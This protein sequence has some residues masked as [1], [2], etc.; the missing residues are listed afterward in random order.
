MSQSSLIL[1]FLSTFFIIA[2]FLVLP[3]LSY[4]EDLDGD[5]FDHTV[6]CDDQNVDVFPDALEVCD[7][8]DNDCD[9][10]IDEA[11]RITYWPDTDA[12]GFGDPA[13]P[14]PS[15]FE[16]EGYINNN[17]DCN[18]NDASINPYAEEICDDGIDNNC[19][20]MIDEDCY[21]PEPEPAQEPEAQ[22]TQEP[23]AEPEAQ[24]AQEPTQEPEAQPTQ[25]PSSENENSG[26]GSS[27]PVDLEKEGCAGAPLF[28]L[29]FFLIGRKHET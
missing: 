28:I 24:P 15:C 2:L 21:E 6:D 29:F 9:G 1:R 8:I 13:S 22:P 26:G 10:L 17:Q 23:E 20:F 4:A 18:D 14:T 27:R 3:S 16:P 25:E 11:L 12:D 19:N 7:D 5:G